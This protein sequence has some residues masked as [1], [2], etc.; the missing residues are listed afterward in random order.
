MRAVLTQAGYIIDCAEYNMEGYGHIVV[1]A[2]NPNPDGGADDATPL[3]RRST[4]VPL[5][6]PGRAYCTCIF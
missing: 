2:R 3:C 4:D 6:D 5:G 1:Q